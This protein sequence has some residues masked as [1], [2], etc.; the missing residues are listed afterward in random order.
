[1]RASPANVHGSTATLAA[2]GLALFS[3]TSSG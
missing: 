3:S 2:V 1:M